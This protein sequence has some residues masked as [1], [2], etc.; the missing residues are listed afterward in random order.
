MFCLSW[1]SLQHSF[2]L[3][4]L[5]RP[6]KTKQWKSKSSLAVHSD[7]GLRVSLPYISTPP[8]HLHPQ[9]GKPHIPSQP[10]YPRSSAKQC[11]FP[12]LCRTVRWFQNLHIH[13]TMPNSFTD[14]TICLYSYCVLR[15]F[16]F[17]FKR[18][19]SS[20]SEKYFHTL[21]FKVSPVPTWPYSVVGQRQCWRPGV[22]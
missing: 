11:I 21:L 9:L 7:P 16:Q 10:C 18:L 3:C 19:F 22:E 17:C 15:Q 6:L 5:S 20:S 13:P 12:R 4:H 8:P 14:K 1:Q 2:P